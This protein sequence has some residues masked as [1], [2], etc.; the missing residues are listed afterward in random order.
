LYRTWRGCGWRWVSNVYAMSPTPSITFHPLHTHTHTHTH[1]HSSLFVTAAVQSQLLESGS[2]NGI[3]YALIL[4]DTLVVQ[5]S[6]PTHIS[7]SLSPP[8]PSFFLP[9]FYAAYFLFR[10][11]LYP[12]PH[13]PGVINT[14][15]LRVLHRFS[16]PP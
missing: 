8:P 16:V 11:T 5:L 2:Q 1:T 7:L 14:T 13:P 15:C 10:T 9:S 12:S 3:A 4:C 6:I